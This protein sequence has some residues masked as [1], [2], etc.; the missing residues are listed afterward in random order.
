MWPVPNWVNA[1]PDQRSEMVHNGI[2]LKNKGGGGQ[3]LLLGNFSSEWWKDWNQW[4]CLRILGGLVVNK[5]GANQLASLVIVFGCLTI[6]SSRGSD[7]II[8]SWYCSLMST[9]ISGEVWIGAGGMQLYPCRGGLDRVED[10]FFQQQYFSFSPSLF[11]FLNVFVILSTSVP[12]SPSLSLY[13]P[14]PLLRGIALLSLERVLWMGQIA[15]S[16]MTCSVRPVRMDTFLRLQE[17]LYAP[18]RH[19]G[20]PV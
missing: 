5:P 10:Y 13:L 18:N 15:V 19:W 2:L 20:V 17:A 16:I 1:L 11:L 3:K 4:S 12:Y 6:V 7:W 9:E 8:V 14:S